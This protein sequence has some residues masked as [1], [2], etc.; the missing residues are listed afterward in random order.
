MS[1]NNFVHLHVHTEFSLL[2]G[3]ARINSV[4]AR[5]KALGMNA[6]AITDHGNLYGVVSFYKAALKLDVKPIIGCEVYVAPQHRSLR[7]EVNGVRYY[8]LILLAEND[9][10]YRNLVKLISRANTEGFYY[11]PRVDKELLRQYHGGLIALS[12]CVKGEIPRAILNADGLDN[13]SRADAIIRE[14]IDIFGRDNFFL[15]IQNHGLKDEKIVV[16]ALIKL[17]R[18]NDLGLVVTNDVHYVERADSNVHDILICIQTNKT[19]DDPTRMRYQSDDYYLKSPEEMRALFPDLPD[20]ADNTLKI[21]DRCNVTFEFNRMKLPHYDLPSN[22]KDAAA[23]LNSLCRARLPTRYSTVDDTITARLDHELST[24][25]SMGY[26]NYFLIVWDFIRFAKSKGIAVG[27]GRGSA[28]GSIVAYLLGIT[29]LDPLKYGL[30]FERFLNPERVSMPDID[31]DFCYL[32]REEVIEYV[33]QKYGRDHVGQIV[34]FGTMAAKAAVRD[35]GRVLNFSVGETTR[36]VKMMPNEI[37]FT[38]DQALEAS[39]DLRQAC[40]K[41]ARIKNLIELSK[42][43]EGLPR[44]SSV[45]AAGLVIAPQ[46]LDELVPVQQTDGTLIT[47]FDKDTL[48]ELGLLKMDFLGLRTLTALSDAIEN[49][50][51]SY[52]PFDAAPKKLRKL[53]RQLSLFECPIQTVEDIPL[54]DPI[55]AKMLA[56]GKT[57]AVFQLE[58]AGITKLV[59]DLR[60]Q[61]FNDLISIVALYRPGP[62]GSGMVQDFIDRKNGKIAVEY[63]HPRLKP[64]LNETYGVILYQ[65]QVMEIV[66]ELAGFTLGRADLL[67]RAMGKKKSDILLAQRKD[68]IE[69]CSAR[70][71]DR[72]LAERIFELLL[73]FADYGFNKSHSAAYALLTWRM[74]Y[75]KANHPAEYMAAMLSSV[76]DLDKTTAY[77]DQVRR[78]GL[79]L[80]GPDVN[81]SERQFTVTGGAIRFGL[82]ALWNVSEAMVGNVIDERTRGGDYKSLTDFCRRVD[83]KLVNRRV[84]EIFVKSGAFDSIDRRR[85]ALMTMI[86][87][88][89]STGERYQRERAS[90]LSALFGAGDCVIDP[91]VPDVE[92]RSLATILGWERETLGFYLTGHPLDEYRDKIGGLIR[93]KDITKTRFDNKKILKT[94]GLIIGVRQSITQ[95]GDTMCF[96]QLEDFSGRMGVT[97][98]PRIFQSN[99]NLLVLDKVIVIEG[100]QEIYNGEPTFVA[101]TIM[102]VSEYEPTKYY[103][104]V[105]DEAQLDQIKAICLEHKGD[106]TVFTYIKGAGSWQKLGSDY[107]IDGSRELRE[108][109][110]EIVGADNVRRI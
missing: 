8:H 34:T 9:L 107:E 25:R 63:M 60:P 46:P 64:I 76:M 49:I 14:Y 79:K 82:A 90:G 68:F 67:R 75:L 39:N 16:P 94:A 88:A 71:I 1:Q 15:E 100:K 22:F 52:E 85:T 87:D 59:R 70:N 18:Q 105:A 110:E 104:K 44:H 17:A 108:A 92:E 20:A 51:Q 101:E 23:Y 7:E 77:A 2:D 37:K 61:G 69:G 72:A 10:G 21:A 56:D 13:L 29:D 33:K 48:E 47:Q 36:L 26:D 11:K 43:L 109:L 93:L 95:H 83:L 12:A 106:R 32:R 65:E 78:M 62:L 58:S 40:E 89:F 45:H 99:H 86:D 96:I 55:T 73:H 42:Q 103:L 38:L 24:I 54:A 3:A 81:R 53:D 102:D 35:V 80:L 5:A 6:L 19:V 98:F 74:A 50:K 31:V 91:P 41:D 57:G 66:R 27:P 28:A 97:V 30:L 4:L 84:V